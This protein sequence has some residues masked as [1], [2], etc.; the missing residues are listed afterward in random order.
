MYQI[1]RGRWASRAYESASYDG[2]VAA[3]VLTTGHAHGTVSRRA[4]SDHPDQ[5][6]TLC[7]LRTR[8]APP[9]FG[10]KLAELEQARRWDSSS[11]A[12]SPGDVTVGEPEVLVT[13][14]RIGP[15]AGG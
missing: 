6:A 3:G 1:R 2:V 5:A 15:V 7:T 11:V 13:M 8:P 9:G 14:S 10:E 12:K 4:R